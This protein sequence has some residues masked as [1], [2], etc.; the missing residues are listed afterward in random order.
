M[1]NNRQKYANKDGE[2]IR[3]KPK[4]GSIAKTI[5]LIIIVLIMFSVLLSNTV[6]VHIS[7]KDLLHLQEHLLEENVA[8][9]AKSFGEFFEST[10]NSLDLMRESIDIENSFTDSDI[11]HKLQYLAKKNEYLAL[12]YV[13]LNGDAI[14]FNDEL[15]RINA[16]KKEYLD[17]AFSGK[18]AVVGPYKDELSGKMCLT[19]A[20][21]HRDDSNNII[22]AFC[23]DTTADRFSSYLSD[24]KVGEGG[25]SYVINK[26]MITVAHKQ[27]DKIG[28]DIVA[29]VE[30]EPSLKPMMDI[31]KE[32]LEQGNAKGEYSFNGKTMRTEMMKI[33]NTDWVFASVIYREEVEDKIFSLIMKVSTAGLALFIVMAI[34]GYIMGKRIAKPISDIDNYCEKLTNLDLSL[35]EDAPALKHKARTDEIGRLMDTITSTESTLRQMI[36]NIST[37]SSNTAATA[38]ELTATAQ[39]TNE[40]AIEVSSAVTNI[41]EGATSQAEDTTVAAQSVESNT[42]LVLEMV[43]VLEEL[44]VATENIDVK[45]DEGKVALEKLQEFI[46]NNKTESGYIQK[47]ILETNESA[48]LISKASEMIQSIA[49]QTNLLALNAAIEAARAGEAGKGFAVVAE[50]IRKLAE[51]STRFTGEIKLIIDGLKDKVNTAVDKMNDIGEIV[52]GQD[53]QTKITIDKFNEIDEAIARSNDISK[54][55]HKYS[56]DIETNNQN[57]VGIIQNLSAIAE[58]NAATTQQA[59]ASVDTQTQAISD[60]SNASANLA[61]IASELQ[62]EVSAFK[63]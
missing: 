14:V 16:G 42:A 38:E 46:E 27:S 8:L 47:T 6:S 5:T 30:K 61:E 19:I 13:R 52:N 45:K 50:E 44:R 2:D 43:K 20:V 15:T 36:I 32:A 40:S 41:A 53:S 48:E 11:Q 63:L 24:I 62:L 3:N 34:F 29:I 9:N 17:I 54:M 10:I 4:N 35:N 59:N 25:Y 39:S 1:K 18:N 55:V 22:G 7:K 26:D 57:I 28:N 12:Y 51:D 56:Q 31:A 60:I 33:P 37:N 49:D 21:P 58:E 23:I